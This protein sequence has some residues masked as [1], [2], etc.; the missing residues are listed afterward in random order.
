MTADPNLAAL[1]S[2]AGR[3]GAATLLLTLDAD[4]RRAQTKAARA[5]MQRRLEVE[6]DPDG[7]LDP[8][9]RTRKA[10][11][12]RKLRLAEMTLR[13]IQSRRRRR[14]EQ[15]AAELDALVEAELAS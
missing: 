3:K 9:E 6:V 11:E 10:G 2:A 8:V 1:R 15:E 5:E 4:G 14:L 13:S 7:V 12:L